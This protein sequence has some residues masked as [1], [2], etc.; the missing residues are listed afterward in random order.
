VA[1]STSTTVD[2]QPSAG[3]TLPNTGSDSKGL[4][5]AAGVVLL[6]GGAA[7]L[8]STQLARRSQG[9]HTA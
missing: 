2:I 6:L 8:G 3:G 1:P 5:T 7:L 9:G 4:L